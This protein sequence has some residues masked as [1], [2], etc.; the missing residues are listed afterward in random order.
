MEWLI[1]SAG[2]LGV[3]LFAGLW[4]NHARSETLK[5]EKAA[6][7]DPTTGMPNGVSWVAE[8]ESAL[9]D[10]SRGNSNVAAVLVK[11]TDLSDITDVA[12]IEVGDR[13]LRFLG[14]QMKRRAPGTTLTTRFSSSELGLVV[15]APDTSAFKKIARQ[16]HDI[17]TT[18]FVID[19]ATIRIEP[20]LGLGHPNE[21]EVSP[22]ELIRR[23]RVALRRAQLQQI[24]WVSYEPT[25]DDS[26]R[27]DAI[28]LIAQADEAID[29]GEF[30]LHYQPKM[31]LSNDCPAGVEGLARWRDQDGDYVPPAEFMPKL[32][33]TSLIDKFSRFV[34]ET[35][36]KAA[37]SRELAPVSINLAPRNLSN[38]HL[39]DALIAAVQ[40]ASLPTASL[41]VEIT[42]GALMRQPKTAAILLQKLRDHGIGVSIDDFGTGYSSFAYLRHLPATN[43]KIDQQFVSPIEDD[44]RARRLL[45][46]MIEGGH[47][48]G[49][50]VTA[51]GVE[52][53][54]QAS[55]LAEM[56][57]D[58]GQGFLWSPAVPQEQLREWLASRTT[59]KKQPS[60]A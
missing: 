33:N 29:N 9:A 52:T 15:T 17:A 36:I 16:L 4:R 42:E 58:F 57:C 55:T 30:E 8:L 20:V 24:G 34:I 39:I 1:R 11:V 50:T 35:A 41:E 25:F 28:R 59:E 22:M 13:I 46:A 60:E 12:G 2:L 38:D 26:H 44:E 47:A 5:R 6:R 18:P 56:G 3:G 53:P 45:K 10:R 19:G 51:E 37:Y 48:L 43:L 54:G 7:T 27:H 40:R 14:I 49:M 23:A 31:R 32:E 21:D